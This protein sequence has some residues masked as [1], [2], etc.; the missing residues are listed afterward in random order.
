MYCDA[1]GFSLFF[2]LFFSR[3]LYRHDVR[4]LVCGL[5]QVHGS[6]EF[7]IAA[8]LCI[9]EK[10]LG[11]LFLAL[12]CVFMMLIMRN[13]V[14]YIYIYIQA[15]LYRHDARRCCISLECFS[16]RKHKFVYIL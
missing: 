5:L 7:A 8:L 4:V 16:F 2:S 3:A 12:C 9:S 14:F 1:R 15:Y 11:A 6:L 10:G 13:V